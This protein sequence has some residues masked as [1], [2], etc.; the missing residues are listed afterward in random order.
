MGFSDSSSLVVPI[1]DALTLRVM[2]RRSFSLSPR[3]SQSS[4]DSPLLASQS[5]SFFHCGFRGYEGSRDGVGGRELLKNSLIRHLR[6]KHFV[7]GE[8]NARCRQ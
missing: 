7:R 6:D 2:P 4:S 3:T 1:C 8:E 5:D